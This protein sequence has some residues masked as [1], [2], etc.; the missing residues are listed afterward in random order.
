MDQS[1]QWI[2]LDQKYKIPWVRAHY[3]PKARGL[4]RLRQKLGVHLPAGTKGTMKN[5]GNH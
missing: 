3:A 2:N 4:V 1:G 5:C